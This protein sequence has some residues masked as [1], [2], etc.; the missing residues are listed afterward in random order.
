MIE[1]KSEVIKVII[2][3]EYNQEKDWATKI[4]NHGA[5]KVPIKLKKLVK[6]IN[7]AK[8]SCLKYH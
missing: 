7:N 4:I 8:Y 6:L 3:I 1:I 2:D 5:E